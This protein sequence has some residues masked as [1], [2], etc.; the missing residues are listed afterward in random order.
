M[1]GYAAAFPTSG[2]GAN[3]SGHMTLS[4][5]VSFKDGTV[6]AVLVDCGDPASWTQDDAKGFLYGL[7]DALKAHGVYALDVAS[8]GMGLRLDIWA[9][10]GRLTTPV[11]FP[12]EA[13]G[14][15][16][17]RVAFRLPVESTTS[18]P[19]TNPARD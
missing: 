8:V 1:S 3:V 15:W 5:A 2:S 11:V 18:G 16:L 4:V 19:S 14:R 17:R 6:A 7:Y 10:S 9:D 13:G 12:S